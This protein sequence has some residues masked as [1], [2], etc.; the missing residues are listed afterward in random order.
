M[1]TVSARAGKYTMADGQPY[2]E[3]RRQARHSRTALVSRVVMRERD[4]VMSVRQSGAQR[5]R[6]RVCVCLRVCVFRIWKEN[7]LCTRATTTCGTCVCSCAHVLEERVAKSCQSVLGWS[8]IENGNQ[9][10]P[11]PPHTPKSPRKSLANLLEGNSFVLS[12]SLSLS[13]THTHIAHICTQ[14]AQHEISE[15]GERDSARAGA[16][17][18]VETLTPRDTLARYI[19]ALRTGTVMFCFCA[20]DESCVLGDRA[21][22]ERDEVM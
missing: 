8:P 9:A 18:I 12:L 4:Y 6:E 15:K 5:G 3:R 1:Y 10:V 2:N 20:L 21:T 14:K 16:P 7:P 19:V 13:Y 22:C 11:N 17:T